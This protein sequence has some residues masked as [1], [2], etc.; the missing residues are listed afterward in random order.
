MTDKQRFPIGK[1]RSVATA[2][3]ASFEPYTERVHIAGSIRRGKQ[4]VGDIEILYIPKLVEAPTD[5]FGA[6]TGQPEDMLETHLLRM[7][8]MGVLAK[9]GGFGP[10]NKLLVHVPSGIP[11]DVFRT[12]A[13][14]WGM[15]LVVRTGP[16]DFNVR[17]MSRF[18]ELGIA[19]H[20]YAGVTYRGGKRFD[21]P[22]EEDVFKHA[23]WDYVEPKER[24]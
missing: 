8:E 19:G 12:D 9:R 16:K 4:E 17:L 13:A 21:C 14:N 11:L 10:K 7:M 15:A 1:A 5:L 23:Q 24:R 20:A 3:A 2:L 18:Q 6:P 22:T